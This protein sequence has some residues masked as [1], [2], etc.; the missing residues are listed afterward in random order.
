MATLRV[1]LE[2]TLAIKKAAGL[3]DFSRG[4]I[5]QFSDETIGANWAILKRK[6]ALCFHRVLNGDEEVLRGLDR[7]QRNC[8]RDF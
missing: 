3:L 6:G 8:N 5:G 4:E 7:L 1:R 2:T